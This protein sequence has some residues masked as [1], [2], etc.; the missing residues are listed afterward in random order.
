MVRAKK[1]IEEQNQKRRRKVSIPELEAPLPQE[2]AVDY[3]EVLKTWETE[4][5]ALS[6]QSFDTTEQAIYGLI[7]QVITRMQ[8]NAKF[9]DKTRRFLFD[10]ISTDP[11]IRDY[12]NSSLKI[13]QKD[14]F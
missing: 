9:R 1:K 5:E 11:E 4:V 10:L 14:E 6:A 2:Q 8:T 7:D 3:S 12:L 13:R